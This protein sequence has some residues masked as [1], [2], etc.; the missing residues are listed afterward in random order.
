MFMSRSPPFN[1]DFCSSHPPPCYSSPLGPLGPFRS[2]RFLGSLGP[3]GFNSPNIAQRHA[4]H[5]ERTAEKAVMLSDR[6][7]LSSAEA[8]VE[9]IQ[10]GSVGV[11]EL[12]HPARARAH[13]KPKSAVL[14]LMVSRS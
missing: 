14:R 12:S 7:E 2:F 13:T 10:G 8:R 9:E 3:L 6:V 5:V 1:K 4:L 11:F